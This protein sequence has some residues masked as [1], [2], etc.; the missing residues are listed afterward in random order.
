MLRS[1]KNPSSWVKCQHILSEAGKLEALMFLALPFNM[2]IKAFVK[3][4]TEEFKQE[5]ENRNI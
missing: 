1:T 3:N 4:Y 5:T 2:K